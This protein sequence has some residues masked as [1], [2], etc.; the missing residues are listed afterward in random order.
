MPLLLTTMRDLLMPGLLDMRRRWIDN[1]INNPYARLEDRF[2]PG[3]V[4]LTTIKAPGLIFEGNEAQAIALQE[5]WNL[6]RLQN[7]TLDP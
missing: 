7:T 3:Q 2:A 5:Y 1:P 4:R 6:I